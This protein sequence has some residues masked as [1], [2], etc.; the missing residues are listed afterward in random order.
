LAN[1]GSVSIT[2]T[3]P[4]ATTVTSSGVAPT[5]TGVYSYDYPTTQAG[6]HVVR[7][8]ATGANAAA[9]TDIFDVWPADAGQIVSL[10]D[11]KG[12]VNIPLASTTHD[13][14]LMGFVRSATAVCEQ[15]VGAIA[16]TAFTES[17][18]GGVSRVALSHAPV[19]S[20]TSVTESGN[21]LVASD[22]TLSPLSGV[23]TRT[24]N[25]VEFPF[26]MGSRNVTVSY[27][28][29]RTAT[30]P[31]VRQAALIIVQHM[32]ETQRPA[33]GGPFGQD[34]GDYDPRYSYSVPRRALELLGEPVGGIA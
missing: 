20:V 26:Y 29:G 17:F 11:A 32:W 30:P 34:S 33:G 7:W 5:S 4:D 16:R 12:Q 19:L 22:Y 10:A 13:D 28:A 25:F 14:E 9:F 21:A 15:Y 27:L 31:N 8:L 23:L 24:S 2:I 3:L 6:R 1:A 18:D